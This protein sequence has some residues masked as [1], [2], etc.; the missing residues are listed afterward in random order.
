M[1]GSFGF[2]RIQMRFVGRTEYYKEK[3]AYPDRANGLTIRG[4]CEKKNSDEKRQSGWRKAD[5]WNGAG[6]GDSRSLQ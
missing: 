2:A 5:A 1:L 3:Q 4:T 6:G